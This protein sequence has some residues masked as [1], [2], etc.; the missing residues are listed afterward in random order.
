MNRVFVSAPLGCLDAAAFLVLRERQRPDDI[1]ERFD[2][3]VLD[4]GMGAPA[5]LTRDGRVVIDDRDGWGVRGTRR[6]VWIAIAAG[7]Q[8]TGVLALYDLLPRRPTGAEP[9]HACAGAR[10]AGVICHDCAGL[11]WR[12]SGFDL[13]EVVAAPASVSRSPT[14]R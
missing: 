8:K 12:S 6:E 1:T 3:V 9:C 10:A 4:P 5:Y 2:A 7:T 13:D 11:G 14:R